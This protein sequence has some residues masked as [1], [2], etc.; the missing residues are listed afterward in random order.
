MMEHPYV[1]G[2]QLDRQA[3]DAANQRTVYYGTLGFMDPR[4]YTLDVYMI[5]RIG[6]H[7]WKSTIRLSGQAAMIGAA[8][9]GL[10]GHYSPVD[11][12]ELTPEY[13]QRASEYDAFAIDLKNLYM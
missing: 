1:R 13:T 8:T 5:R 6:K 9:S 10:F 12:F 11:P 7:P 4:T 3:I 2:G